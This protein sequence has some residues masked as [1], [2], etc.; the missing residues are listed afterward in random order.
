MALKKLDNYV[1]PQTVNPYIEDLK[2]FAIGDVIEETVTTKL[3]S[4]GE[5]VRGVSGVTQNIQAGARANGL[6]ARLVESEVLSAPTADETG[7]TRLVFKLV[8]AQK[9]PERKP[10]VVTDEA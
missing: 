3:G 1:T 7:E 10:K 6:T 5:T 2:G 9:S 4:D 8:A